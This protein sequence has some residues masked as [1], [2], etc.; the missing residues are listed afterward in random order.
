MEKC[1]ILFKMWKCEFELTHQTGLKYFLSTPSLFSIIQT[2]D[3][4]SSDLNGPSSCKCNKEAEWISIWP[5][6]YACCLCKCVCK[7]INLQ[8]WLGPVWYM[9]LKTK[10]C[11]LNFF[12][13]NTYG[14]KSVWKYLKCCLKTENCYL[15]T[16]TKHPL[17]L[18]IP[19]KKKKWLVS[20]D[21]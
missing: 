20:S 17:S 10:N 8:K 11:C 14:W 19:K 5:K 16:L 9:Y 7:F 15:E 12:L 1:I 3:N 21:V 6:P 4:I 2:K 18:L 13:G